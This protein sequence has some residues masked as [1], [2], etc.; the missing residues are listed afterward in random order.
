MKQTANRMRDDVFA[1]IASQR[2]TE[3]RAAL[4]EPQPP[5]LPAVSLSARRHDPAAAFKPLP[6][7]DTPA[8][9]QRELARQR[10]RFAPFM[11]DL[12][13]ALE[14]LRQVMP[15]TMFEWRL[16][17]D[18]DAA[19]FGR[20]L[21][22]VGEWQPVSIPHYG[23]PIGKAT[24][25]Y[26]ATFNLGAQAAPERRWFIR[27]KGV[28]Y[29]AH[30]FVNG[31]YLGSHEGFF[32]PFEFDMTRIA[33]AGENT[34]LVVVENDAI[35][36]GNE[37][38]DKLQGVD[39]FHEGDKVYAATGPGWDDPQVGWHHCPPGMGI[40]Q[41]VFIE[42]R[43]PIHIHDVFVRPLP[44]EGRAEAWIEVN[45]AH[46]VYQPVAL[47]LSV[48]GQN[49]RQTVFADRVF[50]VGDAGPGVNYYRLSFDMPR[51]RVWD[52]DAPWLYQAQV[53]LL[54]ESGKLLDTARCQFG[55]RSF[56][57][58]DGPEA[59]ERGERGR[60]Y[61]NGRQ[62]RLRG[63][64]T[65]G[66]EQQDV[67]KKDWDQLRDDILLARICHMNY[68]RITQRPVQPEV[69]E[70]CDKLGF[71]TQTDLPLFG[72]LRR[73]QFAECV[74]QVEE[75]ERL[76][77]GH[78]C[79]IMISYINEPFPNARGKPHRHMTRAEMESFFLAAD[80][81]V[82]LANP[83]RVIKA[84]DGDY[85]PPAP[86][87]PDNHCYTCWYNGHG[88]EPG[89]LHKGFWQKVKPGWMYGCG[90]FGAEGLDSVE[91]MRKYY[92][93]EWL[94]QTLEEEAAWTPDHIP[95]AQTG[96]YHYMFFE[97]PRTL[98][99]W[100]AASQR[101]Q[102]WATRIMT[103]AFRRDNRMT[104]FAIHLF[105]DAFPDSWMK[106]IMDYERQP[107]P[108]YFAYR[109]ALTPLMA[110][111]RADRTAY[112]A[113]EEMTVECWVCNDTHNTPPAELRYQ[114]EADGRVLFAQRAKAKVE[115]C[116]S[117]FQGF[118]KLRAPQ[119]SRRSKAV[120][121][122]ALFEAN[123][124]QIHD[125]AV[126]FDVFPAQRDQDN[127]GLPRRAHIVGRRNGKA[128][129]LARELGLRPIFAGA[130]RPDDAILIDDMARY[131]AQ[132]SLIEFAVQDGALAVFVE[133]PAGNYEIGGSTLRVEPCGMGGRHFVS[134]DTGH[135]LVEG[136]QPEDFKFWYD[137]AVDRPSPLLDTVL[138]AP[139][140]TP[141][142]MSGNGGW[143]VDWRATPA[144]VEKQHGAGAYRVCQ[145]K[146]A[147]RLVNPVA[148]IFA[149]RLLRNRRPTP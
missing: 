67:M 119:V 68:W 60:L 72:Q 45:N 5:A 34:L 116:R 19:D 2:E 110:S 56:H 41:D 111:L 104:S 23:G 134:R 102:A 18:E 113:G 3:Q 74:R 13:P 123:G 89:K 16:Q 129:Q 79:N 81:A 47:R 143:E 14:S 95:S 37:T 61:L 145:V 96:K 130:I 124:R 90:E 69:Y 63:A 115:K 44:A 114:L 57:M 120:L 22:G 59:A 106:A 58:D 135:P 70:M 62:I 73:N 144:A 82:R 54:D 109:E 91:L 107:K 140:W 131:A 49:F 141:T 1:R 32:A 24:A 128:A 51:A 64:N 78:P 147:G 8:K 48:Y 21:A 55:M 26:R 15:I 127:D 33:C 105:I 30:V 122:L 12:S 31:A 6:K 139:G 133:L 10:R 76:V 94:P 35:M 92:P 137:P 53:K 50:S 146:L 132:Q 112:F 103:E 20:V 17:T 40:Y 101:H 80:Q 38:W 36:L 52:V 25:Y 99:G 100:V 87:L 118:L 117:T 27:F 46:A 126:E 7:L 9:L 138:D 43:A 65:M 4:V 84:V 136:F 93:P 121:R 108:A 75:M 97:T 148:R 39:A 85:D 42:A 149:E 88:I 29:K 28:D 77:R 83:D 125:T 71:L 98:A 142:L 66:F 86:G 11:R